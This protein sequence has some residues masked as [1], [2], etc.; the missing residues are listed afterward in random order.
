MTLL[1]SPPRPLRL[2]ETAEAWIATCCDKLQSGALELWQLPG[3]LRELYL[4]ADANARADLEQQLHAANADADR[5]YAAAL[6]ARSTQADLAEHE[7]SM[8]EQAESSGNLSTESDV[9]RVVLDAA[10]TPPATHRVEHPAASRP[11][12]WEVQA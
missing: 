10:Q 7:A 4:M 11:A 12:A 5:Y 3:S 9:L 6:R 1:N 8:L 2:S